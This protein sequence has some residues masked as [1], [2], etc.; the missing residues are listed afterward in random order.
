MTMADIHDRFAASSRSGSVAGCRVRVCV[1]VH[2]LAPPTLSI[3]IPFK[4]TFRPMQSSCR[5]EI[6]DCHVRRLETVNN[7]DFQRGCQKLLLDI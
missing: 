1:C 3:R 4:C 5:L 6:Q 2:F 7:V